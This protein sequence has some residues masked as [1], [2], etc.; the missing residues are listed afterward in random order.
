[1]PEIFVGCRNRALLYVCNIHNM[2]IFVK[3]KGGA[4]TLRRMV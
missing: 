1:M 3:V 2:D 4:E